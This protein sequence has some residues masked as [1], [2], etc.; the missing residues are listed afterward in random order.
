MAA[1]LAGNPA[2]AASNAGWQVYAPANTTV[3]GATLYRKVGVAGTGYG[4]V[5]R[6]VTPA[7]AN[8]QVFET[9]AGPGRL[10]AGDRARLVRVAL[11]RAPTS[12]ASRSTSSAWRAV[13]EAQRRRGGL[14]APLAR[15]HRADRQR[16]ADDLRRAHERDVRFGRAR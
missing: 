2:P 8:Y 4:Y 16:R 11:G 10:Q 15:G 7:A 5:A 12:T 6:G 14:R 1:V 3:A 9:C 13:P